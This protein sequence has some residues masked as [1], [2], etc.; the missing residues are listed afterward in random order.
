MNNY[1]KK[2]NCINKD[3]IINAMGN[4]INILEKKKKVI[5]A[6]DRGKRKNAIMGKTIEYILCSAKKSGVKNPVVLCIDFMKSTAR[7]NKSVIYKGELTHFFSRDEVA[8]NFLEPNEEVVGIIV[9]SFELLAEDVTLSSSLLHF[10]EEIRKKY[11]VMYEVI[12]SHNLF[13]EPVML[14]FLIFRLTD[15]K[16][17]KLAGIEGANNLAELFYDTRGVTKPKNQGYTIHKRIG[18]YIDADLYN[19]VNEGNFVMPKVFKHRTAESEVIATLKKIKELDEEDSYKVKGSKKKFHIIL[20]NDVTAF[21]ERYKDLIINFAKNE[22]QNIGRVIS[23]KDLR[24]YCQ[25]ET[26][27]EYKV[28]DSEKKT[29]IF[30][31][32]KRK[33]QLGPWFVAKDIIK[34]MS[35]LSATGDKESFPM[36]LEDLINAYSLTYTSFDAAD[37]NKIFVH[38]RSDYISYDNYVE[39]EHLLK[40]DLPYKFNMN[41]LKEF[42]SNYL[43]LGS[44]HKR[45]S[46]TIAVKKIA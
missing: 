32:S 3:D 36:S 22:H 45:V 8:I 37:K 21:V 31:T 33:F 23:C 6:H 43:K 19:Y 34:S 38:C 18:E 44:I 11:K 7:R 16:F 2:N 41:I 26:Y 46:R 1:V 35:F 12:A 42:F 15:T 39:M 9:D 40:E 27:D 25:W 5:I 4:I 20:C 14:P 28:K 10:I 29:I 13:S 24:I 30:I 17:S